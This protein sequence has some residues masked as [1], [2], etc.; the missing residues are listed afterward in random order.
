MKKSTNQTR[1]LF[2]RAESL[3]DVGETALG[4]TG[5][6]LFGI[7]YTDNRS[8][9]TLVRENSRIVYHISNRQ[10]PLSS[11]KHVGKSHSVVDGTFKRVLNTTVSAEIAKSRIDEA[12]RLLR[13]T[14]LPLDQISSLSGFAS[15]QYFT[16]S[17]TKALGES[18][19][20]YR[21][22]SS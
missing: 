7:W 18:P 2:V 14:A 5:S 12:K 20:A 10:G 9:Q 13:Q 21:T 15:V 3:E 1:L 6:C 22:S 17:F 11:P 19:G 8:I 4:A 16:N